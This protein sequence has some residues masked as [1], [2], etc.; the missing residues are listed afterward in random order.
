MLYWYMLHTNACLHLLLAI[1]LHTDHELASI[2]T[3]GKHIAEALGLNYVFF[4]EFEELKSPLRS[5][6][7]QVW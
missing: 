6:A 7:A 4:C 1:R 3:A 2:V 5:K